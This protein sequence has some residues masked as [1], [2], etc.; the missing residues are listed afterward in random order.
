MFTHLSRPRLG[1]LVGMLFA[2]LA[3]C[4]ATDLTAA[5]VPTTPTSTVPTSTEATSSLANVQLFVNPDSPAAAQAAAWQSSRPGDAALMRYIAAQPVATWFGDWNTSI[6]SDVRAV[7]QRAA[8]AG[9]V[10]LLVAYNIP[11]RDCGS[12]SA[13]GA[14]SASAYASWI[15][16]FASG[17]GGRTA[18]VVLEPDALASDCANAARYGMIRNA[19]QVLKASG[20]RVYIDAGHPD[21]ISVPDMASRLRQAGI[22]KADGFSLNVSNFYS[23]SSNIT[24][25]SQLSA[26]VGG[27][28]YVI[29]TSRN[30][31]G[32]AGAQ[33]CNP[34]GMALGNAPTTSTGN[35]KVDAFLWIKVPGESDGTCNG[36]PAAGQWWADYALGLAQRASIAA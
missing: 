20:A 18:V 14:S 3:A 16:G 8:S 12:Y 1:V 30:G 33:W 17:I 25:G 34:S 19:V 26:Q 31:V 4:S 27:K 28:H 6:A 36:G 23:T 5:T 2:P 11:N 15:Q 24:Y 29:D 7:V 32:S 35:A 21:W 9:K 22:D 10:P 13:G